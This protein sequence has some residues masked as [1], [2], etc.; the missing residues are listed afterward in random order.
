MHSDVDASIQECLIN[1]LCE[2]TLATDISQGLTQDLVTCKGQQHILIRL[3]GT[4][5]Q[6]LG[7]EAGKAVHWLDAPCDL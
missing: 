7:T 2:Q 1:L 4:G 6:A 5:P 3:E